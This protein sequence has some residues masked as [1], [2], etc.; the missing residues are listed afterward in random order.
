MGPRKK[1][2]LA[3]ETGVCQHFLRGRCFYGQAC[4]YKHPGGF[5]T[6]AAP[7]EGQNSQQWSIPSF[8]PQ[9]R[10]DQGHPSFSPPSPLEHAPSAKVDSRLVPLPLQRFPEL[11]T[12]GHHTYGDF[13]THSAI[14]SASNPSSGITQEPKRQG[15]VSVDRRKADEPVWDLAETDDHPQYAGAAT[16]HPTVRW[17]NV[18]KL[19][20][21]NPASFRKEVLTQHSRAS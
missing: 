6:R 21:A 17:S 13:L 4:N 2:S 20:D 16:H 19:E 3:D 15:R 9:R 11:T 5:E 7:S 14:G 18:T 8:V 1:H 10:P 12:D